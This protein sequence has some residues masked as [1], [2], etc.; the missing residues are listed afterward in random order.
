MTTINEIIEEIE[1]N[2]AYLLDTVRFYQDR[3]ESLAGQRSQYAYA[4]TLICEKAVVRFQY[5][6]NK[7]ERDLVVLH[8]YAS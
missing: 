5:D 2:H 4:E 3:I 1:A 7:L 6:A 8:Q